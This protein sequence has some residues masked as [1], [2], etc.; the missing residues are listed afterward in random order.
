MKQVAALLKKFSLPKPETLTPAV[1]FLLS[2]WGFWNRFYGAYNRILWNDE[3]WQ[4]KK[5]VGIFKP[6]WLRVNYGDFSTFPGDYILTYPITQW[7]LGKYA[8]IHN[9]AL[10]SILICDNVKW[11]LLIPEIIFTI[12]SFYLLYLVCKHYF[13]SIWA[14]I[15][16][17]TVFAFNY[18]LVWH[19]LEIRTYAF[20]PVLVLGCLHFSW[21]IFNKY[22]NLS[23]L[24]KIG[25]VLFFMFTASFHLFGSAFIF[26]ALLFSAY[27]YKLFSKPVWQNFII[28]PVFKYLLWLASLSLIVWL[29]YARLAPLGE[30]LSQTLPQN[31]Y[32]QIPDPQK[33][34]LG[35]LYKLFAVW[36]LGEPYLI[37]LLI[38]PFTAFIFYDPKIKEKILLLFLYIIGGVGTI[39]IAATITKYWFLDRQ[40]SWTMP[41]FAI[42]LGWCADNLF[43]FNKSGEIHSAKKIL[44]ALIKITIIIYLITFL[45]IQFI[46]IPIVNE[47]LKPFI[48]YPIFEIDPTK[49]TTPE[50]LTP[51]INKLNRNATLTPDQI[52]KYYI[53]L[54]SINRFHTPTYPEI[55]ALQAYC[56]S[57]ITAPA[58][59]T[60]QNLE[61][62]YQLKPENFWSIYNFSVFLFLNNN[63]PQAINTLNAALQMNPDATIRFLIQSFHYKPFLEN[64]HADETLLHERIRQGRQHVWEMLAICYLKL[65]DMPNLI[66]TCNAALQENLG[67]N[68]RFFYYY[69]SVGFTRIGDKQSAEKMLSKIKNLD[70]KF[71]REMQNYNINMQ[72]Y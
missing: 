30:T 9:L 5:T 60:A 64:L 68:D 37:Y 65:N 3:M 32:L 35:F 19:A 44:L 61:I 33:N 31:V 36:I 55:H 12:L 11:L 34:I 6:I 27:E 23:N 59:I 39:F 42:W 20:H 4:L 16:T 66:N 13:I 22:E 43:K 51:L 26:F 8:P 67:Y 28:K 48:H 7:L 40:I 56:T 63:F 24:Q 69:L 17:F 10:G 41:V 25:I 45:V 15:L 21:L 71:E 70:E 62:A 47:R 1:C 2:L 29:W 58:N 49:L 53:F 57:L 46:R 18:S 52:L 14:Y 38:I 54:Q 72:L 50:S